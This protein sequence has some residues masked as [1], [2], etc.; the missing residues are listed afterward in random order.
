MKIYIDCVESPYR[1]YLYAKLLVMAGLKVNPVDTNAFSAESTS[2][3]QAKLLA[4][5]TGLAESYN[6]AE[7]DMFIADDIRWSQRS[8]GWDDEK[9]AD[10]HDGWVE[11][12]N[13]AYGAGLGEVTNRDGREQLTVTRDMEWYDKLEES[14]Q[15]KYL[16]E[17]VSFEQTIQQ[18]LKAAGF[19]FSGD[20]RR[21]TI[22]NNDRLSSLRADFL[23]D[24]KALVKGTEWSGKKFTTGALDALN[25]F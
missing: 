25:M 20:F 4:Q 16:V 22:T 15:D 6:Q 10:P 19:E 7:P 9:Y 8:E 18:L 1:T 2:D 12:K 24:V 14:E 3:E 23:D 17:L 21:Y 5:L 11:S 13:V